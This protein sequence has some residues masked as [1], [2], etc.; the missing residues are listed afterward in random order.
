MLILLFFVEELREILSLVW[1]VKLDLMLGGHFTHTLSLSHC[2]H[3]F[4]AV[5]Y[6]FLEVMMTVFISHLH[7]SLQPWGVQAVVG[8]MLDGPKFTHC[9]LSQLILRGRLLVLHN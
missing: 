6:L 2:T 1:H 3:S 8:A 9:T 5:V 4:D 7:Q